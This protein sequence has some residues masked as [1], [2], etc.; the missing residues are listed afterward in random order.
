MR[1][2]RKPVFDDHYHEPSTQV[3]QR[4]T[5]HIVVADEGVPGA[6][7]ALIH[8]RFDELFVEGLHDE[9]DEAGAGS[10]VDP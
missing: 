2:K 1:E 7:A 8:E 10:V 3:E 4:P 5:H 9:L 6:V